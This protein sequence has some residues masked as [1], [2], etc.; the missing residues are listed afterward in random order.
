MASI[1][2]IYCLPPQLQIAMG[3]ILIKFNF[4]PDG[5]ILFAPPLEEFGNQTLSEI[6]I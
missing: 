4:P 2:E 1:S 5:K 3:G 6:S